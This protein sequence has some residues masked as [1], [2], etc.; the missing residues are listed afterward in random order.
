[1]VP[2]N[3]KSNNGQSSKSSYEEIGQSQSSNFNQQKTL[4]KKKIHIIDKSKEKMNEI[5]W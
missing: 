5:D 1:M 3:K 2:K 4:I